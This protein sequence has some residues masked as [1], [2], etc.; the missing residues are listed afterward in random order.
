MLRIKVELS[1]VLVKVDI[2]VMRTSSHTYR[3]YVP[4]IRTTTRIRVGIRWQVPENS[5]FMPISEV[6]HLL[7]HMTSKVRGH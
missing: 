1:S 5:Y 2:L 7:H 6:V 3:T 4:A